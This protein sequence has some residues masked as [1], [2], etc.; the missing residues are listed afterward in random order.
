MIEELE[1]LKIKK[2]PTLCC[3]VNLFL[4]FFTLFFSMFVYHFPFMYY[5]FIN[6]YIN[7]FVDILRC[8]KG[9]AHL[10]WNDAQIN[11][12]IFYI[13]WNINQDV[14]NKYYS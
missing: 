5:P 13:S 3:H 10:Y 6:C 9:F 7:S 8:D 11:R 2:H 14:Q 4:F 12:Q 1:K